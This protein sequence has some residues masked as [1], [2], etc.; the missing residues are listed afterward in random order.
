M[1]ESPAAL[2]G[3]LDPAAAAAG[4]L[5]AIWVKRS[6]RG[7]MERRQEALLRAGRGL[8]D[9]ADQ[10][11]R[12]QATLIEA[13]VWERLT[14]ELGIRLDPS[15]R[16]ANFM[17]RGLPLRDSRGRILLLGHCRVRIVGETTPCERMDEAWPG[18]QD[19]MRPDWAGGAFGTVLDDG[20]VSVGDPVRWLE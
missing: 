1:A 7:P 6:R 17:V 14:E 10:G 5:E 8:V 4:R 19:A 13:E 2:P 15:A 12:R 18:L 11:G 9:N 20:R 3:I 16:R